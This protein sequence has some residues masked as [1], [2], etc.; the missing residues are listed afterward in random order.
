MKN[1][2]LIL[3]GL[4]FIFTAISPAYASNMGFKKVFIDPKSAS[5]FMLEDVD[6]ETEFILN[7]NVLALNKTADLIIKSSDLFNHSNKGRDITFQKHLDQTNQLFSEISNTQ[8]YFIGSIDN[9]NHNT[10]ES[11]QIISN[12]FNHILLA[13]LNSDFTGL[14]MADLN[15]D[16]AGAQIIFRQDAKGV[17][18]VGLGVVG[19]TG[20]LGRTITY[21]YDSFGNATQSYD[22]ATF[23]NLTLNIRDSKGDSFQGININPF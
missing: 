21:T 5:G 18:Q 6:S 17:A 9:T 20:D 13:D 11:I 4:V 7:K 19:F 23:N 8:G 15:Y 10:F 3:F 16:I 1:K 22:V 12:S 14:L 2:L